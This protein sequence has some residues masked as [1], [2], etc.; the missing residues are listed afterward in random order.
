MKLKK[1]LPTTITIIPLT[2]PSISMAFI[3]TINFPLYQD[4]DIVVDEYASNP[5]VIDTIQQL[6]P[7]N[8]VIDKSEHPYTGVISYRFN[9]SKN[10]FNLLRIDSQFITKNTINLTSLPPKYKN[11]S[12]DAFWTDFKREITPFLISNNDIFN[13]SN[14]P[15]K[16]LFIENG[17]LRNFVIH[18]KVQIQIDK[19]LSP[20]PWKFSDMFEYQSDSYYLNPVSSKNAMWVVDRNHQQN[21]HP[22]ESLTVLDGSLT[23]KNNEYWPSILR[24]NFNDFV[25]Q[26]DNQNNFFLSWTQSQI[27]DY[28]EKHVNSLY[29]LNLWEQIQP[30][31]QN[32]NDK[33][34]V[35][36][37]N[38]IDLMVR[39]N[40]L[41]FSTTISYLDE[42]DI[43]KY[44]YDQ[45]LKF[46]G[47]TTQNN[48][49]YLEVE[50]DDYVDFV[51]SFGTEI[52]KQ[53]IY[54]KLIRKFG[55]TNITIAAG[56]KP[57]AIIS[58]NS[59][60][61]QQTKIN[62]IPKL[63]TNDSNKYWWNRFNINIPYV[64]NNTNYNRKIFSL[65]SGVSVPSPDKEQ[66]TEQYTISRLNTD[67][68]TLLSQAI[69]TLVLSPKRNEEL[70]IN[71]NVIPV[72]L[73]GFKYQIKPN[74]KA[75]KIQ[76]KVYNTEMK[77]GINAIDKKNF[78]LFTIT[79]NLFDNIGINSTFDEINFKAHRW[80]P[81]TN[82]EQAQKINPYIISTDFKEVKDKND[83]LIPNPDY[84]YKIS[85]ETGI[86][87][88]IWTL[89]ST[90]Y[91]LVDNLKLW[92]SIAK[93]NE[94]K[95]I[96]YFAEE[97]NSVIVKTIFADS[98]LIMKFDKGFNK[99]DVF[100][101][102][103]DIDSL[104][105]NRIEHFKLSTNSQET[106]YFTTP[107]GEGWYLLSAEQ[108]TGLNKYY[109]VYQT[110]QKFKQSQQ[111]NIL[112]SSFA[113]FKNL[114]MVNDINSSK[115]FTSFKEYIKDKSLDFLALKYSDLVIEYE[116]FLLYNNISFK[117]NF[118]NLK[119]QEF[120]ED[121]EKYLIDNQKLKNTNLP[122][123][124]KINQN[125]GMVYVEF[126]KNIS[127]AKN[128]KLVYELNGAVV[129]NE[130]KNLFNNH[131]AIF[132][133]SNL[134]P[135]ELAKVKYLLIDSDKLDSSKIEI[136]VSTNIVESFENSNDLKTPLEEYIPN[137]Y[138]K[139][140]ELNQFKDL[141]TQFI[142]TKMQ[143]NIDKNIYS[144]LNSYPIENIE[145][146]KFT[147]LDTES[148][149]N[150]SVIQLN[151]DINEYQI[152]FNYNLNPNT[153]IIKFIKEDDKYFLNLS[154]WLRKKGYQVNW[155][156]KINPNLESIKQKLTNR[157]MSD[158]SL[159]S[160]ELKEFILNNISSIEIDDRVYELDDSLNLNGK[161]IL[162]KDI[163]DNIKNVYLTFTDDNLFVDIEGNI[164]IK[165]EKLIINRSNYKIEANWAQYSNP[166]DFYKPSAL[167][168]DNLNIDEL[169]EKLNS[170]DLLSNFEMNT[171]FEDLNYDLNFE[172]QKNFEILNLLN[173]ID[174]LTTDEYTRYLTDE[175]LEADDKKLVKNIKLINPNNNFI[176]EHI[177]SE[178]KSKQ[179][180]SEEDIDFNKSYD[181]IKISLKNILND[182]YIELEKKYTLMKLIVEYWYQKASKTI[183]ISNHSKTM[184][185]MPINV[186]LEQMDSFEYVIDDKYPKEYF[187]NVNEFFER[188]RVQLASIKNNP[189]KY[190]FS[191][192]AIKNYERWLEL[193]LSLNDSIKKDILY[194]FWNFLET[195]ANKLS[196]DKGEKIRLF[197]HFYTKVDIGNI[198]NDILNGIKLQSIEHIRTNEEHISS[199]IYNNVSL[200]EKYNKYDMNIVLISPLTSITGEY[201][202]NTIIYSNIN[203]KRIDELANSLPEDKQNEDENQTKNEVQSTERI[204]IGTYRFNNIDFIIEDE[205][206]SELKNRFVKEITLNI[207]NVF[208]LDDDVK[209]K[210]F[211][212][213]IITK[214]DEEF[215]NSI[216]GQKD[217][218]VDK[219][220]KKYYK[221]TKNIRLNAKPESELIF[222][223]N[224]F[225]VNFYININFKPD[226]EAKEVK[227]KKIIWISSAIV[228]I[229]FASGI[230]TTISVLNKKQRKV[231]LF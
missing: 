148:D 9:R 216:F 230:I 111:Q 218:I 153:T 202:L 86:Y 132:D 147:Y 128:L 163:V 117:E 155:A 165:D 192:K 162:I 50:F 169:K 130:Y 190:R 114:K 17:V 143:N 178:V 215:F 42:D 70:I 58:Y 94:Q 95:L 125:N 201:P 138:N 52:E 205:F 32:F 213:L 83:S 100:Y 10:T 56:P 30:K 103:N 43:K 2:T 154:D 116:N 136:N 211:N 21:E 96:E 134:N 119:E 107:R 39:K 76:V 221:I 129:E 106:L 231:K 101:L 113:K 196:K 90:L 16:P 131:T 23:I 188:K 14:N 225:N 115:Y 204:D 67:D 31:L 121:F 166:L 189:E 173:D 156:I 127:K 123:I 74:D 11:K 110:N 194:N 182:K 20:G 180:V 55:T 73:T 140:P 38:D 229:L 15:K 172:Y 59:L 157:T 105:T 214:F 222:G 142:E 212:D 19:P 149:K 206:L 75:I 66:Q 141:L 84:D 22:D 135:N 118:K 60:P 158:W 124:K 200:N 224:T 49:Y 228:A 97:K 167:V 46:N 99:I 217:V 104:K 89:N 226:A 35:K 64:E 48:Q 102:G 171:V 170:F 54:K 92:P 80:D 36:S 207:L 26:R 185:K 71:D 68:L 4:F 37:N 146:E 195:Q 164:E 63:Q 34:L 27:N 220:G 93:L 28:I 145:P 150:V 78:N 160:N 1:L 3:N 72:T 24:I 137:N 13:V 203:P 177:I 69:I 186:L 79:E 53:N 152:M 151:R 88:Q 198:I 62:L 47:I 57:N 197:A 61:N 210:I 227:K 209:S 175:E 126:D 159:N 41:T 98:G 82:L 7:N 219:N 161:N 181:E 109:L 12:F 112:D 183:A 223:K 122:G 199:N 87:E 33:Y 44:V 51:N 65:K 5:G 29:R 193:A 168:Y 45:W 191:E 25:F 8:L 184:Y 187:K 77:N 18:K 120:I 108:K 174:I 179:L 91:S 144:Y 133:L 40:K 176:I 81:R 6:F 139:K 85:P 208:T